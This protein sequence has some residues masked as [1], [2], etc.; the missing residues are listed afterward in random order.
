[1]SYHPKKPEHQVD[2]TVRTEGFPFGD[3]VESIE[4][5]ADRIAPSFHLDVGNV[6]N[7]SCTYC[8]LDRS[9]R[10][11]ATASNVADTIRKVAAH[12]IER[13]TLVGGE[14][15]IRKDFFDILEQVRDAGFRDVVLTTNGLMLS[16]PEFVDGLISR[17]VATVHLSL[18]DFDPGV[19]AELSR[20]PKAPPLVLSAFDNVQAREELDLFVYSVVTRRNLGHLSGYV[21]R[22]HEAGRGTGRTAS[23]VFTG[24]KPMGRALENRR[25]VMA[26]C[27]ETADAVTEALEAARDLGVTGTF[28]NIPLCLMGGWEAWS[29]DAYLT[30]ARLDLESGRVLPALRDASYLKG[31]GCGRCLWDAHCLGVHEN[32]LSWAGWDEFPPVEGKK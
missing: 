9:S 26:T 13:A 21:K 25:E 16:Y 27:R 12:G 30:E 4:R 28:R 20:N 8:C 6:C 19:L 24:V 18:D 29:L 22:V 11:Y 14:P 31:E 3:P 17:G 1:M 7:L 15:T 23:V 2:L 32:Y 10:Y 5:L